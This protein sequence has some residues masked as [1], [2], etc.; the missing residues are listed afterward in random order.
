MAIIRA[1]HGGAS[2]LGRSRRYV[3]VPT[4]SWL[5]L[6]ATAGRLGLFWSQY[7]DHFEAF[8]AD[9]AADVTTTGS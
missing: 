5:P 4:R 2:L 7:A 8:V 3:V 6:S 1:I 9:N